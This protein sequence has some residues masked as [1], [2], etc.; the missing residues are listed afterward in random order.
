MQKG[1]GVIN[2]VNLKELKKLLKRKESS[3][4]DIAKHFGCGTR[5]IREWVERHNL[6]KPFTARMLE[7]TG[8]YYVTKTTVTK[9][10]NSKLGKPRPP[11]VRDKIK[12][13]MTPR[14]K[15][16]K[17]NI[18]EGQKRGNKKRKELGNY[19]C[20]IT[21]AKEKLE[22]CLEKHMTVLQM[23]KK[24]KASKETIYRNLKKFELP[25]FIPKGL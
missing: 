8:E 9:I 3:Y 24:F 18:S 22:V 23:A 21:L 16:H 15:I 17:T 10:K 4:A 25:T 2:K 12:E 6:P 1:F 7:L 20:K 14:S 5:N 13:G 11:W 19:R